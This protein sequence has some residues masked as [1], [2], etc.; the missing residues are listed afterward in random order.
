MGCYFREANLLSDGIVGVRIGGSWPKDFRIVGMNSM[1]VLSMLAL[2]GHVKGAFVCSNAKFFLAERMRSP[3]C[4][5]GF[6][7]IGGPQFVPSQMIFV[8]RFQVMS[9]CFMGGGNLGNYSLYTAPGLLLSVQ[10]EWHPYYPSRALSRHGDVC[11]GRLIDK[12]PLFH[13]KYGLLRGLSYLLCGTCKPGDVQTSNSL[14]PKFSFSILMSGF[15]TNQFKSVA[16]CCLWPSRRSKTPPVVSPGAPCQLPNCQLPNRIAEGTPSS[17]DAE[18][19]IK[20]FWD[21]V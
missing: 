18:R 11:P 8:G 15:G 2:A 19:R 12:G 20:L 21:H 4:P 13:L 9:E 10:P 14:P 5:F 1:H 3:C 6:R 16:S 17:K 7:W